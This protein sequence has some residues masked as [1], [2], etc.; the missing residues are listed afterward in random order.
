MA[1][2]VAPGTSASG[3]SSTAQLMNLRC[4]DAF[5]AVPR[6]R[7]T[8]GHARQLLGVQMHLASESTEQ[9][10]TSHCFLIVDD[11]D[12]RASCDRGLRHT[13]RS[14]QV[15]LQPVV[16]LHRHQQARRAW[17]RP[18]ATLLVGSSQFSPTVGAAGIP[19][20]GQASHDRQPSAGA[21]C[22]ATRDWKS[23][24]SRMSAA[25]TKLTR[26]ARNRTWDM[27]ARSTRRSDRVPATELSLLCRGGS[28]H[29]RHCQGPNR[30]AEAGRGM[31]HKA[32]LSTKS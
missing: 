31:K 26:R 11:Q 16:Q 15:R 25:T 22:P 13:W 30:A 27:H 24:L 4:S 8:R 20:A 12:Y 17:L 3:V 10:V 21:T 2:Q 29:G 5:H 9:A 23:S 28:R 19:Q 7:T 14:Q 32:A 6:G 1:R 18:P